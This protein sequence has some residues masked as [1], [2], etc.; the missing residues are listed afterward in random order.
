MH[1]LVSLFI[2][3]LLAGTVGAEELAIGNYGVS[4]NGMPFGVALARA[5]GVLVGGA[6]T[7]A[8][9]ALGGTALAEAEPPQALTVT[10]A[11]RTSAATGLAER[12]TFAVTPFPSC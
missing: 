10:K 11:T 12:P 3:A 6:P 2:G 5:A 9:G 7:V 4:A 8:D 1:R